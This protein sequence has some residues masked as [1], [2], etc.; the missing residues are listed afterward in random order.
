M[1]TLVAVDD[2]TLVTDFLAFL[3]E[4][5][6]YR[7]HVAANGK[8]ALDVIK[9]VRPSLVITDLMMPLSSGLELAQALRKDEA[10]EQLPVILCS[11]VPDAVP[12][13]DRHLFAAML[14]K[15]YAPSELVDSVAKHVRRD[16]QEDVQRHTD[17]F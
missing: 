13:G 1:T 16:A 9:R 5:E 8:Q 15:P 3:L 2:E 17:G 11:A 4:G 7:V 10:F 12:P 6:G 14:Q